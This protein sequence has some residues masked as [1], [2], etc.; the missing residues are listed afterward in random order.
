MQ[1]FLEETID[2]LLQKHNDVSQLTIIL[3]S[4]RAGGFFKNYLR[5]QIRK[6]SFQPKIIS[7]EEFVEII[8]DLTIIDNTQLLLKSYLVYRNT[9]AIPEKEEFETYSS[10]IQTLL[11]DFNEI[12]RYLVDPEQFFNY[13]GSIKSLEKWS[14]PEDQTDFIRNYLTFWNSLPAFYQNLRDDLLKDG[15][16]Y[17]GMV[18]RKAAEEVEHYISVHGDKPHIFI[19]FN[20]LNKAEQTIIKELLETSNSEI[21]WDAESHFFN[22]SSHSASK[23]MSAYFETWKYHINSKPILGNNFDQPKAFRFIEVPQNVAQAKYAGN[24]LARMTREALENTAVVLADESLLTPLLYS[25][26]SDIESVNITMG[27]PIQNFPVSLF[28]QT[29]LQIHQKHS[30]KWYYKDVFRLLNNPMGSK[31]VPSS[32]GIIDKISAQ[33]YTYLSLEQIIT[34]ADEDDIENLNLLFGN[35]RD[36]PKKALHNSKIL[37][38]NLKKLTKQNAMEKVTVFELYKT[39]KNIEIQ[40]NSFPYISSIKTIYALFQEAISHATV[41]FKGDAYKGLQI[42]GVLETRVLDFKNVIMLSVNEGFLPSGK[43]NTS[44]ITYDLKKEFELPLFTDKDAIYTYH[45]YH[46]L[47]R[48][49]NIWLLYNNS[50]EGL[51]AGEKSRYMLQLDIERHPNHTIEKQVVSP[52]ISI[53]DSP[54]LSAAKT[55]AVMDRLKAIAEKGFSPS[56]LTAYIRN[57]FDF[58]LSRV[59]GI[60]ET[61]EVEETVDYQTLGTIVHNCLETFYEPLVGV[62]LEISQLVAMKEKV[63]EEVTR[64]FER[65]FLKGEFRKGKN[66]LIFE[67]AK[68]YIENLIN[69]DIT[70]LQNGHR[71]KLL[72]IESKLSIPFNLAELPFP[73]NIQG[74]VDR[75]DE[76]DGSVRIIDY[77]T[78]NVSQSDVEI[79][80]WEELTSDY[81]FSKAF[82]ILSYAMMIHDQDA[83]NT[84][85]AGIISFKNLNR[86]FLKFGTKTSSHGPRNNR[87]SEDTLHLFA[88]ELK[89][90]VLEICD[91]AI[92]FIEKEV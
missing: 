79:I 38:V 91:P 23:F 64:E 50:S 72:Q 36:D 82:Q 83:I 52:P 84:S 8:S 24:I 5:K 13:L 87:I 14:L 80:N 89:K 16:G 12:D 34:F 10:W 1:T 3:P 90:L 4:K 63:Q 55:P 45:F 33:N 62:K 61:E 15:F 11:N 6:T 66:L 59:L 48:A 76:F 75:V 56:A 73:V 43:S 30:A 47:H 57:P 58:Y 78:G 40:L 7:I 32:A 70:E 85:E 86:G 26:P 20:A 53:T 81:K 21:Y 65:S 51:G 42:M 31:L 35:W 60:N 37:L 54:A 69:L 22:Q 27:V 41:D 68:R 67:V 9:D 77:K 49:E 88:A 44:F 18:Y 29:L 46:L 92:P 17:Q 71:I 19:G 2:D 74:T 28:F 39:F 25:L